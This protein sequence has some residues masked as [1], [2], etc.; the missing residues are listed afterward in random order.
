MD[1]SSG[2]T[3]GICIVLANF[4]Q[5]RLPTNHLLIHFCVDIY[6]MENLFNQVII[7]KMILIFYKIN[8][9]YNTAILIFKTYNIDDVAADDGCLYFVETFYI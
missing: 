4:A 3:F 7:S 5:N 9:Q 1:G 6:V 8:D 2:L